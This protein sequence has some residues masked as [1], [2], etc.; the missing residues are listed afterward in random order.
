MSIEIDG[1]HQSLPRWQ[2]EKSPL[3]A[4]PLRKN[5][6]N[7]EGCGVIQFSYSLCHRGCRFES[8]REWRFSDPL[9]SP[10]SK[11]MYKLSAHGHLQHVWKALLALAKSAENT[12]L[13]L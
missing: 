2:T 11:C 6:P 12:Q 13:L 4:V 5:I 3:A 9:D 7:A 10:I 1:L 8:H